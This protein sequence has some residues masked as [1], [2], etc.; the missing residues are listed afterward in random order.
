[1]SRIRT[2]S[3]TSAAA[4]L[5]TAPFVGRARELELLRGHL[6]STPL[7]VLHGA[8]GAGKSA[9]VDHLAAA[10]AVATT[11][12][13]CRPGDRASSIRA[14]AER[15]LRCPPGGLVESLT[16]QVLLLV[17]D[18][19][20]RLAPDEAARVVTAV[21]P[22][23]G[24]IGR[25]IAIATE[26]LMLPAEID[27]D[28]VELGGLD[29]E[30]AAALWDEL[31]QRHGAAGDVGA[32]LV[33][34]RG[35]PLYLRRE[36]AQARLGG[37]AW[38]PAALSAGARRALELLAVLRVP[39]VP[40]ALAQLDPALALPPALTELSLRQLVDGDG[41]GRLVVH[42]RV[43]EAARAAMA[44]EARA[45]AER[46]AAALLDPA[47]AIGADEG[48]LPGLDRV[49]RLR[50]QVHHLLAAGAR[51]EAVAAVRSHGEVLARR[52]AGG[53]IEALL[54]AI[55]VER[56]PELAALQV[57]LAVRAGRVAEAR[58]RIADG[59]V[60]SPVT[61]AALALA[62]GEIEQAAT[63]LAAI[64]AGQPGAARAAALAA[65]LDLARGEPDRARERLTRAQRGAAAADR[66][67]LLLAQAE[68]DEHVG[69]PGAARAALTRAAG[70]LA[71]G[72][73]TDDELA[74][75]IEARRAASLASEGRLAEARTAL[76]DARARARGTGALAVAE[77]IEHAQ[78]V[79]ELA[80][81]DCEGGARRLAAIVGSRRGRGDELGAVRIELE[82]AEVALRR[83]DLT[84]A[85]E[86]AVA[87][88][89]SAS[90]LRLA[91]LAERAQ[92]VAAGVEL[93]EMRLD[94]AREAL[95]RLGAG[96]GL[97]AQAQAR[98][99]Q[100]AAEV[101]AASG[102]R[103]GAVDA[104]RAAGGAQQAEL[105]RDLAE[106]RVATTAGD[107]GRAL[108]AARRVAAAAARTGRAAELAE[109]LVIGCRLELAKGDRGGARAQ[110]SRA[111]REAAAAGLIR[112][113]AHALLALASLA[114]DDG[115][116]G[117]AAT[118]ARD[119][120]ELAREAGLPVERLA[121]TVALDA[122]TGGDVE[123]SLEQSGA[124]AAMTPAAIEAAGR[125]LS[126]LGLT[127]VRPYRV[128]DAV[129][130]VSEIADADPEVLRLP[131]RTLAVDAVR[132][133]IWRRGTELADLRR[134][135]LLKKLL[136]LFAG[137]PGKTFSKED[138][139]QTVWSVAYHPLRHDAALFTNIMRIRRLLGEDGAEIIRVT[140]D[141]YRFD[142]PEDFVFVTPA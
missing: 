125:L 16:T 13:R 78:A 106:A 96:A 98:A 127:A 53:E 128:I 10:L 92:V 20:H 7:L 104:A 124:A 59:A 136:F 50:E 110:A 102:Q 29:G 123:I 67:H 100:L 107:I 9:L 115:D 39:V 74:A 137:A 5:P 69:D 103:A 88:R 97:P 72:E 54:A 140:E 142:P 91:G 87:A 113:R 82:L 129:G 18:D 27:R 57:E 112:P 68:L 45:D 58:E 99:A 43:Q 15:R 90:R 108:T 86:L 95:D 25:V 8:V 2:P 55:G 41:D 42:E 132:E 24:A 65:E 139:V 131:V 17:I 134:R 38:S 1:M 11:V 126:D 56:A 94:R 6:A 62:A 40:A 70:A 23:A 75:T 21:C 3:S 48:A 46:A 118:Y 133:T 109:A 71:A 73:V 80:R 83:G 52:G 49:D 4:P 28:E 76:D 26:P 122:I 19:L 117:A 77:H 64:E 63:R 32:A 66:I 33:R 114:R 36:H 81:G 60:A 93:G 79:I 111:A 85:A 121:A 130:A 37:E 116:T 101:R 141:G 47:P 138:I 84:S 105:D 30:A 51:A 89:A 61:I 12:V 135:S 119:A 34:T 35:L 31:G 14:R 44:G 120:A 22:P